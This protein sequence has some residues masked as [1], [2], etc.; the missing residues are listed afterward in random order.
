[1]RVFG[2]CLVTAGPEGDELP[3][4]RTGDGATAAAAPQ[5][6]RPRPSAPSGT[7]LSQDQLPAPMR[8]GLKGAIPP[9]DGRSSPGPALNPAID[10]G[11]GKVALPPLQLAQAPSK[12]AD[13]K[14]DLLFPT[15]EELRAMKGAR[16]K[17]PDRGPPRTGAVSAPPLAGAQKPET[18]PATAASIPPAVQQPEAN[19]RAAVPLETAIE[20]ENWAEHGGWYPQDYAVSYR[21]AGHKDWFI[22]A[23]LTLTGP[24]AQRG[25]TGPLAVVFDLLT[26][27]DAQG[28]CAKCHSVDDVQPMGRKINFSPARADSKKGRFT[29][30]IHEPH[31][32]TMDNRGCL[33]CHTLDRDRAYQKTFEQGNPLIAVSNFKGVE[34]ATCVTCHTTGKARQDCLTCHVY[35]LNGAS[36]PKML[37]KIPVE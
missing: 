2:Q 33:T 27:K 6:T 1:V 20:P 12:P 7:T 13:Q 32:G 10:A 23:W 19:S 37:T 28:S 30:F 34:K 5:P 36:S 26:N 22:T 25:D 31:L 8:A 16:N 3:A 14:D 11:R 4:A 9:E 21:P 15:D 18:R 35:H 17:R 29:T 24:K